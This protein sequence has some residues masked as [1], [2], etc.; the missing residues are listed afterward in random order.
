MRGVV[1]A[2]EP[3]PSNCGVEVMRVGFCVVIEMEGSGRNVVG[4]VDE[5]DEVRESGSMRRSDMALGRK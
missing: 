3:K 5:K 4:D 2:K 1:L